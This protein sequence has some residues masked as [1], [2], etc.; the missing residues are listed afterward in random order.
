MLVGRDV[1]TH[2]AR[3]VPDVVGAAE[4]DAV[5]TLEDAGFDVVA[6]DVPSVEPG[7]EVVGQEPPAGEKHG[8]GTA[9][10]LQVSEGP[11]EI[12]VP[13]MRGVAYA[14]AVKTL[15]DQEFVVVDG[16]PHPDPAAAVTEQEPKP[17]SAVPRGSEVT[18]FVAPPP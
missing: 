13:E 3:A 18:L 10:N 16:T 11:P 6:E 4:E 2:R 9:V 8:A 7:G 12:S 17:G 1:W 14:V 5:A 15:E